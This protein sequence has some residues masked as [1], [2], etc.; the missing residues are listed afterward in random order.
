MYRLW[1]A[2]RRQ[3]SAFLSNLIGSWANR[4]CSRGHHQT[5]HLLF[6]YFYFH[7]LRT[8]ATTIYHPPAVDLIQLNV[9]AWKLG[10]SIITSQVITRFN[11]SWT[12]Y[13]YKT[14]GSCVHIK[15]IQKMPSHLFIFI[16]F[17]FLNLLAFFQMVKLLLNHLLLFVLFK[18]MLI[19]CHI[20]YCCVVYQVITAL[21]SILY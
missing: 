1:E 13:S 6:I 9:Y 12:L 17:H 15:S 5:F 21:H 7:F 18:F 3:F 14:Y 10:S 19:N 2:V 20:M 11:I 16:G 4:A 8:Y